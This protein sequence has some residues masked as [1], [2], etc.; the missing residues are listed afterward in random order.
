M[1]RSFFERYLNGEHEAVWLELGRLRESGLD[2]AT[3][4]DVQA[5]AVE[6]M[7]RVRHNL[8]RVESRLREMGF[9][10]GE[11]EED[12]RGFNGDAPTLKDHP[13]AALEHP[14]ALLTELSSVVGGPLPLALRAFATHVGQVDFRGF[15]EGFKSG[16]LLDALMVGF[17]VPDA[18]SVEDWLNTFEDDDSV[19]GY[20]WEFAPDE[21]HKE[22][23]SG[24]AAY[25]IQLP[26]DLIDPPVLNTPFSG[27]FTAYLRH[28]ILGHACFAG[29]ADMPDDLLERLR[30]GLVSF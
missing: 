22:N 27:S 1:N 13:V 30:G 29:F 23:V 15:H 7:K 24:G 20:W 18:E 10:F 16:Y 26:D 28:C 9:A 25:S 17:Y 21:Y 14:E 4:E 5:V 19:Q 2:A 6:T 3:L 11:F 8:E 12:G